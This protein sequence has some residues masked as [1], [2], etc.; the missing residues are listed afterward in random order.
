MTGISCLT[1]IQH[2][3]QKSV[4]FDDLGAVS[5]ELSDDQLYDLVQLAYKGVGDIASDSDFNIVKACFTCHKNEQEIGKESSQCAKCKIINYCSK[6][7][8]RKDWKGH[9]K[10]CREGMSTVNFEN[11]KEQKNNLFQKFL[12]KFEDGKVNEAMRQRT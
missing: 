7:C 6:E 2:S 11:E 1:L 9:K 5:D 10:E 12:S 3:R 8:Q 4:S